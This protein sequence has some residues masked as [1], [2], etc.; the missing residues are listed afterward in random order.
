MH[1]FTNLNAKVKTTTILEENKD[2][3]EAGKGSLTET[4]LSYM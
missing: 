3:P 1:F 2:F 4:P